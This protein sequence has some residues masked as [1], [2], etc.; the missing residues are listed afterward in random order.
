MTFDEL[1]VEEWEEDW[2]VGDE[3]DYDSIMH[4]SCLSGAAE[5]GKWPITRK[6]PPET[7]EIPM[8]GNWNRADAGPSE[9]DV[10]RVVEIYPPLEGDQGAAGPDRRRRVLERAAKRKRYRVVLPGGWR[11]LSRL[12]R[13]GSR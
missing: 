3:Y 2:V 4:Y 13:R 1:E 8:G 5:K 7:A 11:L 6:G 9:R 10:K 12:G